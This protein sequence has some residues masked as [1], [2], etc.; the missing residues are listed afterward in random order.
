MK[1]FNLWLRDQNA[2]LLAK[3]SVTRNK[4]FLLTLQIDSPRC[5]KV[6]V[7]NSSW[8]W[9]MSFGHLNFGGLKELGDKK[10]VLGLPFTDHPEQLCEHFLLA[11]RLERV[12]RRKHFQDQSNHS[13]LCMLIY[14]GPSIRLHFVK[15]VISCFLLMTLVGSL[16]CIF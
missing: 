14:V 15:A 13:N 1:I 8:L 7:K 12:F 16:G 5:L 6:F 9:H 2:N 10:M 3:V 11:N 4:M